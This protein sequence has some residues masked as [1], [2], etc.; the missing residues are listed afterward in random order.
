MPDCEVCI[1]NEPDGM[2][3]FYNKET[4]KARKEHICCEC[5]RI[6][7]KGEN[8]LVGAGKYD[9]SFFFDKTCSICDEIKMAFIDPQMNAMEPGALWEEMRDYAF[10]ELTTTCFDRLT[11]PE[12]KGYLRDRWI[13]WKGI[14]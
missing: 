13:E 9:G 12:A 8:Y 2:C 1:G 6:I 7:T 3:D 4:R 11:T 10:P 14:A 5:H